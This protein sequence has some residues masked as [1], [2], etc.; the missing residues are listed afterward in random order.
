M[1]E[2]NQNQEPAA[3]TPGRLAGWQKTLGVLSLVVTILGV[4]LWS[5]AALRPEAAP[6]PAAGGDSALALGLDPGNPGAAGPPAAETGNALDDWSPAIFRLGF[7]FFAAFCVAYAFRSFLRIAI[8][9]IGLLLLALFGL[10]Y[11]GL[12]DVNWS[13]WSGHYDSVAEW[14]R[15]QTAG[16]TEFIRGVL[17]SVGM[18]TLGFIAGFRRRH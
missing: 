15:A 1:S 17:P 4:A 5:Y 18:A 12:I 2:S 3:A 14:L 11:A 6:D 10:Q 16:F 13:T 9:S 7:S 8:V